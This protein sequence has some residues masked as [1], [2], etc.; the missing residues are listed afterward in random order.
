MEQHEQPPTFFWNLLTRNSK[1]E[2]DDG[3]RYALISVDASEI[4]ASQ[5]ADLHLCGWHKAEFKID[6]CWVARALLDFSHITYQAGTGTP[7]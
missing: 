7:D 6:H 2:F 4:A 5:Q 3:R 1:A